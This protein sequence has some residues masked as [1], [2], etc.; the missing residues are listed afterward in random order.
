MTLIC[1]LLLNAFCSR[2]PLNMVMAAT[3][4]RHSGQRACKFIDPPYRFRKR[5]K[6]RSAL[7]RELEKGNWWAQTGTTL[8]TLRGC[9]SDSGH[10]RLW[11]L[12]AN[13]QL[14][15]NARQREVADRARLR[16]EPGY[17]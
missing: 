6:W 9:L 16:V 5:T 7:S 14:E 3:G 2:S 10:T 1:S 17:G 13:S 8:L 12:H 15:E 11:L 4:C